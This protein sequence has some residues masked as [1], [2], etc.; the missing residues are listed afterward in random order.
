MGSGACIGGAGWERRLAPLTVCRENMA[1]EDRR[2]YTTR[3]GTAQ[4]AGAAERDRRNSRSI[5]ARCEAEEKTCPSSPCMPAMSTHK[6]CVQWVSSVRQ[7]RAQ[8]P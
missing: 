4:T 7:L 3:G 5:G 8:R 1:M 2:T 6:E